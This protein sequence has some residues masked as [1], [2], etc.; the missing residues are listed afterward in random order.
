MKN[1]NKMEY[2]GDDDS[3]MSISDI[4]S[5]IKRTE[6]YDVNNIKENNEL[7]KNIVDILR[8]ERDFIKNFLSNVSY[9]FIDKKLI[10]L[11]ENEDFATFKLL[12]KNGVE[13]SH[14]SVFENYVKSLN[15]EELN[16]LLDNE[17]FS[18]FIVTS[19]SYDGKT[20][21]SFKSFN[22]EENIIIA[23][24][25]L[26]LFK[27][28]KYS[29]DKIF[30]FFD[31]NSR[32]FIKDFAI[33]HM[34]SRMVYG[35]DFF[36]NEN[37]GISSLYKNF[38]KSEYTN[39]DLIKIYENLEKGQGFFS[40]YDVN[41]DYGHFFNK[42]IFSDR[43]DDK[44]KKKGL[45]KFLELLKMA[46]KY[47][48][49][50]LILSYEYIFKDGLTWGK[51][52]KTNKESEFKTSEHAVNHFF[53]NNFNFDILLKGVE[54]IHQ[55][56]KEKGLPEFD[57]DNEE[58]KKINLKVAHN[59]ILRFIN[60]T[61]YEYDHNYERNNYDSLL[62]EEKTLKLIKLLYEKFPTYIVERN[63]IGVADNI[64]IR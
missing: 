53:V 55:E 19:V 27:E 26:N 41:A 44:A 32:D 42:A 33:E 21:L 20:P 29:N 58:I 39:E 30:A 28:N 4:D 8:V 38:V 3:T 43:N 6:K 45:K 46:E 17:I 54:E 34:P 64:L 9:D 57:E 31:E 61:Y 13:Y 5:L 52:Y 7:Y 23:K 16:R 48:K 25:L 50:Y 1:N 60:N 12:R 47:P 10:K 56:I 22:T 35:Y 51:D 18:N 36:Y 49:F 24:K 59:P 63:V 14:N 2:Y 15:F 40:E 11:V 37:H 62:G